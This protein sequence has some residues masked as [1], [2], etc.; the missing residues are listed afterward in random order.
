MR[1]LE[2]LQSNQDG[3]DQLE[4]VEGVIRHVVERG[5]WQI[6]RVM[7]RK[8]GSKFDASV[9]TTRVD[10]ADGELA[11]VVTVIRDISREKALAE[12]R[13]R[14]VAHASHELRTPI[15]NL[16]TRLHLFRIRPERAQ[17]HLA[18]LDEVAERMIRLVDDLLDRSRLERGIITLRR[19]QQN[20]CSLLDKIVRHQQSEA[21]RRSISLRFDCPSEPLIV[22]CDGERMSQVFTNLIVNAIN[23]SPEQGQVTVYVRSRTAQ[24]AEI[25]VEDTGHGIP[26]EHLPY[27]FQPFFRVPN[28]NEI[29]GSGLGLSIAYELVALHG[30]ELTAESEMGSGSRFI[31]RL[32]LAAQTETQEPT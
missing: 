18:I 20:I 3:Q 8:D 32:P 5:F 6:E 12:Q 7:R 1:V 29:K 28:E 24:S 30:G 9:I 4:Q 17:E 13:A 15:T 11:G 26:A 2:L 19:Q 10:K 27:I 14:F 25:V 21:E 16:M 31:V 23:Y 22:E